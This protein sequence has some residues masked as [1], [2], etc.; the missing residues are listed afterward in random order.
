M[1]LSRK[2]WAAQVRSYHKLPS[3]D[4][5]KAHILHCIHFVLN[6]WHWLTG[7]LTTEKRAQS[8]DQHSYTCICKSKSSQW[9]S[10][11]LSTSML[12]SSQSIFWHGFGLFSLDNPRPCAAAGAFKGL[13]PACSWDAA[14]I[15]WS[16]RQ[17][18]ADSSYPSPQ[19]FHVFIQNHT[20]IFNSFRFNH[21]SEESSFSEVHDS[22]HVEFS[23]SR[24]S[25]I[26]RALNHS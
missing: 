26:L 5:E 7:C 24:L 9:Y 16:L 22:K 25:A 21:I 11:I 20:T 4:T 10:Q 17:Q 14:T 15:L 6:F 12:V 13:L 1:Q 19:V 18:S 8:T 3:A 2:D 23:P